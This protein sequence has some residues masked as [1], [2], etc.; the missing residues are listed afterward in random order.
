[1]PWPGSRLAAAPGVTVADAA[2]TPTEERLRVSTGDGEGR[3][4]FA[5]LDW[6]GYTATLAGQ[7]LP[8]VKTPEGLL[9]VEVPAG[10]TDAEVSVRFDVPGFRLAVPLLLADVLVALGLGAVWHLRRRALR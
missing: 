1:M 5:R 2:S 3:L 7:Q 4:L 6:P 10:L 9:E 8:M